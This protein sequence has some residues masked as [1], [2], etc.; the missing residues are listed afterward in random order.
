[1]PQEWYYLQKSP[2]NV[3][4]KVLTNHFNWSIESFFRHLQRTKN[5]W[6]VYYRSFCSGCRFCCSIFESVW[7]KR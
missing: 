4:Y 2:D 6:K 7:C 3:L 5:S 1:L